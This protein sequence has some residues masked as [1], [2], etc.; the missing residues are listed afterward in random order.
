MLCNVYK[1]KNLHTQFFYKTRTVYA[2]G[3]IN[4]YQSA[5]FRAEERL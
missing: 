4:F 5:D 3:E 2:H 1:N